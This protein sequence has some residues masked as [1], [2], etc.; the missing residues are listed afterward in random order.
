M[1]N[2]SSHFFQKTPKI[3]EPQPKTDGLWLR[4]ILSPFSFFTSFSF[5]KG[6]ESLGRFKRFSYLVL[7]TLNLLNLTQLPK[8]FCCKGRIRTSTGRLASLKINFET[9]FFRL[10]Y[11][12][13]RRAW[14]PVSTPHIVFIKNFKKNFSFA[15]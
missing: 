8:P 13:D 6:L 9:D 4:E 7:N 2:K 15:F 14:L 12:R 1:S 3:K 11:P 10:P 5:K